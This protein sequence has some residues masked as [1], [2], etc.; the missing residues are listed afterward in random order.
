MIFF[1]FFQTHET[2]G[3]L[4]KCIMCSFFCTCLHPVQLCLVSLFVVW[5]WR[6]FVPSLLLLN[7]FLL[8]VRN[9]DKSAWLMAAQPIGSS[10]HS[11]D[12]ISGWRDETQHFITLTNIIDCAG[13]VDVAI[14]T[15][16]MLLWSVHMWM[17]RGSFKI[18]QPKAAS[19][20][21]RVLHGY[22]T[23]TQMNC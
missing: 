15:S 3:F 14:E 16:A 6:V 17:R 8:A 12:G 13:G 21:R 18:S 4:L 10:Y 7:S 9:A 1:F 19:L 20:V 22:I 11:E 5:C 2:N 23:Q